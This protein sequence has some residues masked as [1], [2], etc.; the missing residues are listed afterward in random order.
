MSEK[1]SIVLGKNVGTFQ[2]RGKLFG[3]KGENT[4]KDITTKSNKSM[5]TMNLGLRLAD[6]EN[7]YL[8][9]QGMEQ[10]FVWFSKQGKNGEK[11]VT[12]K[13][14]WKK[15]LSPKKD[16]RIIGVNLGLVKDEN[17]KNELTALTQF[18]AVEYIEEHATDEMSVF[19][20]GN[21]EFSSYL[22][23]GDLKHAT[24]F[25]PNAIYLAKEDI[26]FQAEKF[27]KEA[28]F[29]QNIIFT[30]VDRVK[31]EEGDTYKYFVNGSVV[32]YNVIEDI[33]LETTEALTKTFKDN[34]KSFNSITLTG[35][36]KSTK[37]T[38]EVDANVWGEDVK[39]GKRTQSS[40]T[41]LFVIGARRESLENEKY[42]KKTVEAY[43]EQC[44]E[45]RRS[46]DAGSFK[47]QDGGD[48]GK[49]SKDSKGDKA[50]GWDDW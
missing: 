32:G 14:E 3:V 7:M 26:D 50:E 37:G 30:G 15:R 42:S 46:K 8:H 18:D 33:V 43:R 21:I 36:I 2:A 16:F 19:V 34:I 41:S 13:V 24:K 29:V 10:E 12:E 27:E 28:E 9:L 44:D 38:L 5:R 6:G 49:D 25:V 1:E 48:W 40:R 22:K 47:S 31:D 20:K 17:G 23:D 11:P 35:K 4:F 39:V 45:L